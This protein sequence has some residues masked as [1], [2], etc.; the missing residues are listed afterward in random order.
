MSKNSKSEQKAKS[1]Y[2]MATT[3]LSRDNENYW[4]KKVY[5][6]KR[7]N[8]RGVISQ[9]ATYSVRISHA[10]KRK[11][12]PLGTANK[13]TAA[14][15][16]RDLYFS[17][18][19]NGWD[20]FDNIKD[21]KGANVTCSDALTVGDLIEVYLEYSE[22]STKTAANYVRVFR[23]VV[24]EIQKIDGDKE[25]FDYVHGG[26]ERW[27]QKIDA[28]ALSDITPTKIQK[29]RVK[30]VR[31]KEGDPKEQ[32]SA[33]RSVNSYIRYCRSLF[34]ADI[35]P[36]LRAGLRERGLELPEE[37]PFHGVK[38]YKEKKNRYAS[39]FDVEKLIKQAQQEL[40]DIEQGQQWLIFV[41]TLQAGLRRNEI[42]KLTWAQIDLKKNHISLAATKYFKPKSDNSGTGVDIDPEVSAL[43]KTYKKKY[44]GEFVIQSDVRPLLKTKTPQY[45]ANRHHKAL[46]KWLRDHGVEDRKPIHALRKEAGSLVCQKY[47]LFA[48]ST[49]LRH[50]D[51]QVT[52]DHYIENKD[53]ITTGLGSL[54]TG[55][56][57][58]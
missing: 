5:R 21:D 52:G 23:T 32:Q 30:R 36:H 16:A 41:L 40:P 8:M 25:R 34:A 22:A 57:K 48:A 51:T 33:E 3:P 11:A 2:D 31:S 26:N 55:K 58:S 12:I 42:D 50:A 18:A 13:K 46:I 6:H 44:G 17:I 53:T 24:A 47:G 49:F 29:W 10:G 37:L 28:V 20:N 38:L 19:A 7:A 1:G 35:L 27:R 9:D 56:D 54:L 4:L 15:K 43:L 45:R 39:T 14:K